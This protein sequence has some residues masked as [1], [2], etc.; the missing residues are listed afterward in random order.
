MNKDIERI[1]FTDG[2]LALAAATLG[3]QISDSY[4]EDEGLVLIC[5]LKGA[6]LFFTDLLRQITLPVTIQFITIGS[7]GA[8][9]TSSGDVTLKQDIT[10]DITGKDVL[11]VEDIIDTG[12]TLYFLKKHFE[13]KG[14][15]SVRV[16]AL[17]NKREARTADID[18]DFSGFDCPNE[19][20]VGYGL[21]Y[22]EK[23]RNL[24]YVGVLKREIYS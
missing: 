17:L 15:R 22:A 2:Q 24:S 16:C 23:Y 4:N 5:V 21:D 1:A 6:C 8:G 12:N 13:G 10:A 18:A 14:A 3:K 9:T 20:L 19:F 11:I 7:Y